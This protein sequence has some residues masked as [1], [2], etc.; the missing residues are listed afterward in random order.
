MIS[1]GTVSQN[2]YKVLGVSNYASQDEI[3][4]AYYALS[5]MYHSDKHPPEIAEYANQLFIEAQQAYKILSD[6]FLKFVYDSFGSNGIQLVAENYAFFEEARGLFE[7]GLA[8]NKYEQVEKAKNTTRR[9]IGRLIFFMKNQ[10]MQKFIQRKHLTIQVSLQQLVVSGVIKKISKKNPEMNLAN[11]FPR[12]EFQNVI[13]S[14]TTNL[15][16]FHIP[17]L[18]NRF[19]KLIQSNKPTKIRH[20]MTVSSK[21]THE[22]NSQTNFTY[23][24]HAMLCKDQLSTKYEIDYS[25]YGLNHSLT[26]S[27]A[28]KNYGK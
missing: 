5:K 18:G 7:E 28:V 1:R 12:M 9:E 2:I 3:K 20:S 13:C 27:T 14:T 21:L 23:D 22:M 8:N 4:R 10:S 19:F 25:K 6:P 15:P 24:I 16:D 17:V 11:Y 26:L